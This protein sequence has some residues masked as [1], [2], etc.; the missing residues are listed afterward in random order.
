MNIAMKA[1]MVE[2]TKSKKE[3]IMLWFPQIP[4]MQRRHIT[5]YLS[6]PNLSAYEDMSLDSTTSCKTSFEQEQSY[7]YVY[8]S[9]LWCVWDQT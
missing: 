9:S 1:G 3:S 6:A 4:A 8:R 7:K 5:P 2:K